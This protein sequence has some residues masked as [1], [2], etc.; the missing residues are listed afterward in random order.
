MKNGKE[1]LLF[2]YASLVYI[3]IVLFSQPDLYFF[4]SMGDVSVGLWV[5]GELSTSLS[6]KT[7]YSPFSN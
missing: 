1:A 2:K 5:D 4:A 7:S 3:R 6:T